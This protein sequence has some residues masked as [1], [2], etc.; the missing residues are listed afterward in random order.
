M[1]CEECPRKITDFFNTMFYTN[2]NT[3]SLPMLDPDLKGDPG[4]YP[5]AGTVVR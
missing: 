3:A 2:P 4:I 5:P 1:E